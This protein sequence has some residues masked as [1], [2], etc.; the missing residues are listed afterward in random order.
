[1]AR[2]RP[3]KTR[4]ACVEGAN[5]SVLICPRA[6]TRVVAIANVGHR[7]L[8]PQIEPDGHWTFV[9]CNLLARESPAHAVLVT[10]PSSWRPDDIFMEHTPFGHGAKLGVINQ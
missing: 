10:C 1:M 9:L 6:S 3:N 4:T 7:F 2:I 8:V 5:I